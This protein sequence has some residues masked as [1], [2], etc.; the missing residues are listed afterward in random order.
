M[1]LYLSLS[2]LSLPLIDSLLQ[3]LHLPV[4]PHLLDT[5]IQVTCD[6]L[7]PR[8]CPGHWAPLGVVTT[9]V[10]CD[11]YDGVSLCSSELLLAGDEDSTLSPE[12]LSQ[13]SKLFESRSNHVELRW[14]LNSSTWFEVFYL[15]Q[16]GENIKE[17]GVTSLVALLELPNPQCIL[18]THTDGSSYNL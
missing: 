12:P 18:V 14:I 2:S 17:F 5:E 1:T 4:S 7:E 8:H 16:F 15:D 13:L 10:S 9:P 3:Y 6:H 11:E